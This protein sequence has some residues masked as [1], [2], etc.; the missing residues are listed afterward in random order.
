MRTT[1]TSPRRSSGSAMLLAALVFL[2]G[3]APVFASEITGLRVDAG[4]T[5]T[6]AEILLD[7]PAA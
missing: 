2:L 4:P 3:A 5:G 1:A 7:A 6:R